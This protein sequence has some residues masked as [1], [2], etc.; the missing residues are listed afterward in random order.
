MAKSL[1]EYTDLLSSR[2]LRWPAAPKFEPALATPSVGRLEGIKM[3]VWNIY[4]TLL[5][6][7]D[8][9]LYF[10]HPEAVRMEVALEKTIHE[11]NMWNSMTRKPGKPWEYMLQKYLSAL[12][13]QQMSSS[14]RKGDTVEVNT[15]TLWSKLL[16]MLDKKD[17]QYDVSIYGNLNQ[18]AEKIAYFFHNSLQGIEAAPNALAALRAIQSNGIHQTLLAEAQPFTIA[19]LIR[20]LRDQGSV[21]DPERLFNPTL[22]TLSYVEGV[23]KP[24]RTLYLRAMDRFSKRGLEPEQVLYV[25]SRVRH[26]LAIAKELGMRT[27]LYAAERL[28][29][30]ASP[31]DLK[32]PAIRPDRLLTDLRQVQDIIGV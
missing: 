32:D 1:I 17:Y 12:D 13:E 22:N 31:N 10:R 9:D 19:Q 8:G 5:R 27:A 7:A 11:F 23:R 6:I 2:N 4:G 16:E 21:A 14:G 30:Q 26:D 3:V 20:C 29:L 15:T 18:L 28:S 25:S 24:A